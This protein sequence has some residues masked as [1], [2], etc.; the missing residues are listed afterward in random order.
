MA[1]CPHGQLLLWQEQAPPPP[2]EEVAEWLATPPRSEGSASPKYP[3]AEN[4]K[5]A[6]WKALKE[7]G[8]P[9]HWHETLAELR[10][11][12]EGYY[13][14]GKKPVGTFLEKFG[15]RWVEGVIQPLPQTV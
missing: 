7:E 15:Y 9:P 11:A 12:L 2:R 3:P 4:P 5:E 14:A 10:T 6:P 8:S 1:D 13:Q